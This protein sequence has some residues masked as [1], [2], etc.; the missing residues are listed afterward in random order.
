MFVNASVN[1]GLGLNAVLSS[2]EIVLR[3]NQITAGRGGASEIVFDCK[4]SFSCL[5]A[6]IFLCVCSVDI[7]ER[8]C[9]GLD[10]I[11]RLL[12]MNDLSSF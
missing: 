10:N 4:Y 6:V 8:S 1:V 5:L 3:R 9:S 2:N 7:I 11:K 12:R